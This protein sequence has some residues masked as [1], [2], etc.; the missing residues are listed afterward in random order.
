MDAN[1][2]EMEGQGCELNGDE[3]EKRGTDAIRDEKEKRRAAKTRDEKEK[4]QTMLFDF[5]QRKSCEKCV[6]HKE[7]AI[8]NDHGYF[9]GNV[10]TCKDSPVYGDCTDDGFNCEH[11]KKRKRGM[12]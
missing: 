3:K 4:E 1:R 5:R 6:Y 10:C 7:K 11:H 9:T 12:A 2:D 8:T